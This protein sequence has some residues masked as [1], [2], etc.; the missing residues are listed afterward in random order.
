MSSFTKANAAISYDRQ[1]SKVLGKD[2]YRNLGTFRYYLGA[3]GS[4][5][6]IE[7]EAGVLS[8]GATVPFPVNALITAW[9][10][11]S[12]AVLLHDR[13]CNTYYKYVDVNGVVSKVTITRKEIDSILA[14]AM[15]VLQVPVA[16]RLAIM[17][18]VHAYRIIKQPTKPVR[19][20]ERI[21]LEATYDPT[22]FAF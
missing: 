3:E 10:S 12:Q 20:P 1:A 13:L 6:W 14:E 2:F 9:G 21:R 18:G 5:E 22:Q 7:V 4:K 17:A 16:K 19:N 15:E 11:Y 8:D